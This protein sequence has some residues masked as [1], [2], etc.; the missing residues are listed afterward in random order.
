[1]KQRYMVVDV[2]KCH[3]CNTC[4]MG[5]KD[6]FVDNDWTPYTAAQPKHGHR[7]MNILR[8]ERGCDGRIDVAFLPMPCQHCEDAPCVE[9]SDGAIFRR[10][11]G[12]VMIDMEKAKGKKQLVEACPYK[13]IYWNEEQ[14][15]PQK[16]TFC[17]HILDNE[18][19]SMP[20]CV[21][22]CPT[23]AL[24]FHTIEP[25][26]M[27]DMAKTEGL[28]AYMDELGTKPR[29][30]YKNLYRYTKNFISAGVVH[31]GDCVEGAKVSLYNAAGKQ[32]AMQKT[33]FFGE[34]K[35]DGLDDGEYTI[36]IELN[37]NIK[38]IDTMVNGNSPNL[39]FVDL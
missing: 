12:I 22:N 7:W 21:H 39:G 33:N 28:S 3:D 35:F 4:F 17:A 16:C 2:E 23:G 38:K 19:W 15:V 5:C 11:D 8:K 27:S 36:E 37:G 14:A 18:G 34:F 25:Y 29:V 30:Y 31:S 10:E 24:T 9:A 32:C 26:E 13:A 6:E 1:M 20:R